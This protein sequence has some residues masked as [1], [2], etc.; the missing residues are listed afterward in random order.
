MAESNKY[1]VDVIR[2]NGLWSDHG[3]VRL[4]LAMSWECVELPDT[5]LVCDQD[6]KSALELL[7]VRGWKGHLIV[8]CVFGERDGG[9]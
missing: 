5:W 8:M 9:V 6:V 4:E 2:G 1:N 7:K 3:S